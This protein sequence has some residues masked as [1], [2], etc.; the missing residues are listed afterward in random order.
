MYYFTSQD[1]DKNIFY[2]EFSEKHVEKDKHNHEIKYGHFEKNPWLF[3]DSGCNNN[4]IWKKRFT[5]LQIFERLKNYTQLG[6]WDH[7]ITLALWD[8]VSYSSKQTRPPENAKP[9][10]SQAQK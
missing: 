8:P 7:F 1:V 6:H 2:R 9:L 4:H 5:L 3:I 10:P